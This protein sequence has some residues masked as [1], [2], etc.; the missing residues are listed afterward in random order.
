MAA[1]VG[2][3]AKAPPQYTDVQR[4][5]ALQS[6]GLMGRPN[7]PPTAPMPGR[8]GTPLAKVAEVSRAAPRMQLPEKLRPLWDPFRYK[9]LRGGRGGAKSHGIAR[10]LLLMAA[11]RPMRVLCA[12]ELQVSIKDS[13][14]KLLVDIIQGDAALSA[15]Y[16]WTKNSITN[17]LGSEFIFAGIRNN[18]TKIKSMEGIDVCWVEEAESVSSHSWQVLIPTIRK[19]GSEI[20]VSF[21]PDQEKDPTSQRFIVNL[22]PN[23]LEIVMS[24]EDNPWF[25]DELRAEMEYLFKIDPDAAA[26]V[27]G[28]GYRTNSAAQIFNGRYS[29]ESFIPEHNWDGPYYGADWGFSVDPT[30]LVKLYIHENI[31]YIYQEAYAVGC[32]IDQ[33]PELFDLVPGARKG[34]IRADSARPETISYMQRHGYSGVRPAVKWPGSVEDGIEFLKSF[35]K[36]VIHTQC[37]HATEEAKLYSYK[38]DRLTKEPTTDIDDKHNHIWDAVRYA[39]EPLCKQSTTGMLTY[40]KELAAAKKAK[41]Q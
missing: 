34:T 40:M 7:R 35:E 17:V 11:Q 28:G 30:T 15:V 18:I 24:W 37:K 14:H 31:L 13:V 41:E 10:T 20:W 39:L 21:N 29:I 3:R 33:T 27:W 2:T 9:I 16:S 12:R 22:P 32:D 25:P 26:H 19:A 36:I 38:V 4:T 6:I 23:S 8:I 5:Q 1:K